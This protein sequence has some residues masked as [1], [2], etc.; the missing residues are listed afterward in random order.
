MWMDPQYRDDYAA[1]AGSVPCARHAV[2]RHLADHGHG[3]EACWAVLLV[4]SE[5]VTNVV[6]HAYPEGVGVFEVSAMV[7]GVFVDI[8][9]TDFGIGFE[10]SA[11]GDGLGLGLVRALSETTSM[12]RADDGSNRAVARVATEI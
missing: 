3:P 12:T 10:S 9:V 4:V 1:V 8:A 5:L 7:D 11:A 6:C 2:A